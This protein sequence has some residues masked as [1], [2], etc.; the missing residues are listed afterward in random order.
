MRVSHNKIIMLLMGLLFLLTACNTDKT[1]YDVNETGGRQETKSVTI[2][3]LEANMGTDVVLV[4]DE[5]DSMID[6]DR[7]RIAL[8]G[9]KLFVDME[10]LSNAS[11]G[12]VEFSD[13]AV[14][15]QMQDVE[16]QASKEKIKKILDQVQYGGYTDTGA[17]LLEAVRLLDGSGENKNKSIILFT[18]G[19]IDINPKAAGRTIEA[20]RSDVNTA[21]Q[22]AQEK[23]YTIYCIGLNADG[24]VDEAQLARMAS[25]TGGEYL[26]AEDVSAITDFFET[27]FASIGDADVD[28]MEEYIADGDYHTVRF[29]IDNAN[30]LEANIIILST[31][32][33]EDIYLLDTAGNQVDLINSDR[34]V[35]SSSKKYTMVKMINPDVGEWSISVKG[36]R[37]DAI[38]IGKIFNYNINLLIEVDKPVLTLG[39]SFAMKAYFTSEGR[40]IVD[41]NF[42]DGLQGEVEIRNLDTEEIERQGFSGSD[43]NGIEARIQPGHVGEY[44]FTVHIQGSGFYRDS[45]EIVVTVMKLPPIIR[46]EIPSIKILTGK[47]YSIDLDEYFED[48]D[49]GV[50]SYIVET[51]NNDL[52]AELAGTI[53]LLKNDVS[54]Q[55]Q[56]AV[57]AENGAMSDACVKFIVTT[58]SLGD[59]MKKFM[60]IP[61]I[62]GIL[63]LFMVLICRSRE[64]LSG[65]FKVEVESG[66]TDEYGAGNTVIYDISTVIQANVLGKHGYNLKKFLKLLPEYYF[67]F[68]QKNRFKN[69]IRQMEAMAGK[70]RFR[71]SRQPF[72]L[73]VSGADGRVKFVENGVESP[74]KTLVVVL[75]NN[76]LGTAMLE[77]KKF[78]IRFWEADKKNYH[79]LNITYRQM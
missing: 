59:Q 63:L 2:G 66:S 21:V 6:A 19:E 28:T 36:V 30:I 26:I 67:D 50:L 60:P 18:D 69:C 62:A 14:V 34:F 48:P 35:F 40:R 77:E 12:L 55:V 73:K 37:G 13:K 15:T 31:K 72:K 11:I 23:G 52:S 76:I 9:A 22:Q 57:H 25:A 49:G 64:V 65:A 27:F 39:D 20:S 24:K 3:E 61:I 7:E 32:E 53:L 4:M 78:S 75:R 5:S 70:V 16:Q 8:E 58:T 71:G 74:K 33:V 51:G 56:V 10:K 46:K 43:E 54:Q 1:V 79:Q 17:A 41:G 44:S 47:E 68:E 29:Q 42:Y 45:D 38:K